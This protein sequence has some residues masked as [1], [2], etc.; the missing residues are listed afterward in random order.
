MRLSSSQDTGG[1]CCSV[2]SSSSSPVCSSWVWFAGPWFV[3]CGCGGWYTIENLGGGR[4]RWRR[5]GE[6]E[7][8][9]ANAAFK[10]LLRGRLAADGEVGVSV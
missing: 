2:S 7:G 10:W 1:S 8:V 5:W 9:G 3:V 6:G 4:K